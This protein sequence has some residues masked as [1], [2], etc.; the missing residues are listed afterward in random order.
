MNTCAPP[1]ATT[2]LAR[3]VG[4]RFRRAVG[5][6]VATTVGLV[7]LGLTGSTAFAML[8]PPDGAGPADSVTPTVKVIS[9]GVETWQVALIA[10]AAALLG[11]AVAL[12]ASRRHEGRRTA[13]SPAA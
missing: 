7:S 2:P 8:A 12:L 13:P 9:T 4:R 5:L 6:V 1:S 10:A 3:R 11:A